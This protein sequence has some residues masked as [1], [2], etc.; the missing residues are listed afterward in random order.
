MNA[1]VL[2][3]WMDESVQPAYMKERQKELD[4]YVS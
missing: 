4:H 2:L 3:G 1:S